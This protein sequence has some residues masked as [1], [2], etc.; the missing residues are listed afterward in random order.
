MI[1]LTYPWIFRHKLA[2]VKTILDVGC[3]NG[4]FIAIVNADKKYQITG[5]D[6]FAPYL[7]QAKKYGVYKKLINQ[8]IKNIKFMPAQFDAVISSQ[9]IEHLTTKQGL[10][11]IKK[12]EK[13]ANKKIIIGT[14]NGHFHQEGYDGNHLQEH[15]SEWTFQDFQ[16]LGYKTYGQGLKLVYGEHGLLNSIIGSFLPVKILLFSI[17]FIMSPFVYFNPQYAAHT[18]AVKIK[19]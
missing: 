17:S 6:L 13:Y 12:L 16:K 5:V 2:D 15:H 11:H 4:E 7:K 8:D 1:P 14:P 19:E 10:D 18:I 3:G 9:V